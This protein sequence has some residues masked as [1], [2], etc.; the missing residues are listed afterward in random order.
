MPDR[1]QY[2]ATDN[3]EEPY[4]DPPDGF[5][6]DGPWRLVFT[7]PR[8][9]WERGLV[10]PVEEYVRA[11]EPVRPAPNPTPIAPIVESAPKKRGRPKKVKP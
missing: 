5:V 2:R 7:V 10:H 3:L 6:A 9:I 8:F 4:E 1:Y 11:M